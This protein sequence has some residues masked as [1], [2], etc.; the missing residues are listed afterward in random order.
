VAV[1]QEDGEQVRNFLKDHKLHVPVYL[2]NKEPPEDIAQWL[3]DYFYFGQKRNDTFH[4]F[5]RTKLGPQKG[6]G[7]YS[8]HGGRR[9]AH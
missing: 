1:T 2:A 4:E 3:S 7:L 9:V 5:R 8:S 6:K